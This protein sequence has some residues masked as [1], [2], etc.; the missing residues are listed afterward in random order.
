MPPEEI[1]PQFTV[2]QVLEHH[3]WL[4]LVSL[5]VGL[6]AVPIARSI[7]YR[8][9]IVDKP[10]DLLKPHG[11]PIAYLGGVGILVAVLV[12][13]GMALATWRDL[14]THW[15]NLTASLHGHGPIVPPPEHSFLSPEGTESGEAAIGQDPSLLNNPIWRLGAIMISCI[16]ITL[17][18][19][20]DDLVNLRPRQKIY[21]QLIAAGLLLV[22]GVADRM[23]LVFLSPLYSIWGAHAPYW[24]VFASSTVMCVIVVVSACNATNL[25]D[26]LDGL[27]G[28]VTGIIAAG[29]LCLA[30]WLAMWGHYPKTDELRLALCLAMMGAV[31]GFLPYNYPPASI[32]MGDAG[33]MLLGFFVAIMMALFCREGTIR[34]FLGACVVFALPMLDTGLAVIRRARAGKNIFSGDRSHLYDQL[35][36]RGMTVKQVV[37]LFYVLAGV[38]ATIGVVVSIWAR[39][40]L[41][42]VIYLALLAG[43][44]MI[45]HL[46]GMMT[47]AA[48]EAHK[49]SEP[50][51]SDRNS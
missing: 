39:T 13:L 10:D 37:K 41:A 33:S 24:L 7:A 27:C 5:G 2:L 32:F 23:G 25:L 15:T 12:G 49:T 22:G 42:V 14:P 30:I 36:D 26:G 46:L 44:M 9:K 17:V 38:A 29:F 35:V 28:G 8:C 19:L 21:G 31:L 51:D 34:W 48:K 4:V 6:I 18:G 20:L 43:V 11:R 16:V 45:F 1:E 47:P 40:R 3:W 50:T